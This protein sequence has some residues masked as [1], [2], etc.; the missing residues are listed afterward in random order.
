M[1]SQFES[2]TNIG[3]ETDIKFHHFEK[4]DNSKIIFSFAVDEASTN[5]DISSTCDKFAS[6]KNILYLSETFMVESSESNSLSFIVKLETKSLSHLIS[7]FNSSDSINISA[8]QLLFFISIFAFK[9][10]SASLH[11]VVKL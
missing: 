5:E 4:F 8:S 7:I 6:N 3:Y 9:Y 2:L 1:F 11:L 10:T